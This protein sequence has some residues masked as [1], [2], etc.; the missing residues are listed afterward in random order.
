MRYSPEQLNKK[1]GRRKTS[2]PNTL[3]PATLAIFCKFDDTLMIPAL[4]QQ[5]PRS[6][7]KIRIYFCPR[8]SNEVNPNVEPSTHGMTVQTADNAINYPGKKKTIATI[9]LRSYQQHK[10]KDMDKFINDPIPGITD[11]PWV[12]IT[13]RT[14][15]KKGNISTLKI[16]VY[17]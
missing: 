4:K 12:K 8:C 11:N 16:K 9:P 3:A 10:K 17:Q 1:R 13:K 2:K 15:V 5:S 14:I 7:K 6:T